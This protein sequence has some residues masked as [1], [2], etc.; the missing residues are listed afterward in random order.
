MQKTVGVKLIVIFG[1]CGEEGLE[2][3][4]VILHKNNDIYEYVKI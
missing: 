4:M 3:E 1:F 2:D